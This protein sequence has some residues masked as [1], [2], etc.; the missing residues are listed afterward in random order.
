MHGAAK[1][2]RYIG[3]QQDFMERA[4]RW[5]EENCEKRGGWDTVEPIL[6]SPCIMSRGVCSG[7]LKDR[8]ENQ[9]NLGSF[10]HSIA[11]KDRRV[12]KPHAVRR[13]DN[14]FASSAVGHNE[15]TN[16]PHQRSRYSLSSCDNPCCSHWHGLEAA[17]RAGGSLGPVID[18]A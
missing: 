18:T 5:E 10:I 17:R 2:C 3:K 8:H 11:A 16:Y 13:G 7:H 1:H 6:G 4:D 14:L 15:L 9:S 12:P